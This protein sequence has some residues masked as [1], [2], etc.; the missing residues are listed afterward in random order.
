MRDIE[1]YRTYFSNLH[2]KITNGEKAPNKAILLLSIMELIRRGH[3]VSNHIYIDDV[4]KDTFESLWSSYIKTPPPT[5]WTPFWHMKYEPFWYFQ[6]IHS[7]KDIE[8]LVRPG[9]TASV[10]KMKSEIRY[11]YLDND[12]YEH[13]NTV[14][15]RQTLRTFLKSYYLKYKN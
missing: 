12:L 11:A 1:T 13:M 14:E 8:N 10:G 6:P 2:V 9:Q 4:V 15:G 3:I 7:E 5:V